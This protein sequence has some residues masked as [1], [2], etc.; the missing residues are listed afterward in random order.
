MPEHIGH[1]ADGEEDDQHVVRD[2]RD[3][4]ED[5]DVGPGIPDGAEG[6]DGVLEL[7]EDPHPR[8]VPRE[9]ASQPDPRD[10]Q[11]R[12]IRGAHVHVAVPAD[13]GRAVLVAHDVT[14]A[15]QRAT[16]LDLEGVTGVVVNHHPQRRRPVVA[17]VSH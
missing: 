5:H 4:A 12:R 8:S 2:E 7:L 6:L 15:G 10:G 3:V 1:T 9:R 17:G 14:A 11:A 16:Q 13:V